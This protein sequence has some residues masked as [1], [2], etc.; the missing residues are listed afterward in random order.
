MPAVRVV[1]GG[2]SDRAVVWRLAVVAR[3]QRNDCPFVEMG[4]K[5]MTQGGPAQPN[6]N[7]TQ[8]PDG[9]PALRVA[10]SPTQPGYSARMAWS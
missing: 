2:A 9:G 7:S 6:T 8:V 3:T 5:T 1:L 4:R 10:G